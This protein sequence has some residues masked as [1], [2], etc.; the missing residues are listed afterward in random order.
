MTV[1]FKLVEGGL[2][3]LMTVKLIQKQGRRKTG[4]LPL[5]FQMGAE[6]PLHN[7]IIGNFMICQGRLVTNLLQLFAHPQNSEWFSIIS[8]NIFEVD[9]VAR[10][11]ILVTTC[12]FFVSFQCPQFF[13]CPTAAPASLFRDQS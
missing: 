4:A 6:V 12:L 9:I 1:V 5:S 7:S 13:Y 2:Y 8:V 3:T 10:K 11:S